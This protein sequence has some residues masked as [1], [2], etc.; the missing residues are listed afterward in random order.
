MSE[1]DLEFSQVHDQ[2][3][4][5]LVDAAKADLPMLQYKPVGLPAPKT[6]NEENAS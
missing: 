5:R 4:Q 2:I 3:R 6:D 1:L